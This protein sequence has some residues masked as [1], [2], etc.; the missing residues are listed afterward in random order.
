MVGKRERRSPL[1]RGSAVSSSS[2]AL[3]PC[4]NRGPRMFS[5][6]VRNQSYSFR[7]LA[8]L[9]GKANE[10]RS[11]DRTVG[12]AAAD[13]KERVAAQRA[14]ADVRLETLYENPTVP[15]ERCE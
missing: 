2:A 1:A 13:E 15:Y 8:E 7:S 3:G 10:E 12:L 14:L 4:E 9:L 6:Q 11:G 5:V